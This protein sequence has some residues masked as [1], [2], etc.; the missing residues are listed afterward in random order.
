M[1]LRGHLTSLVETPVGDIV[2]DGM[3]GLWFHRLDNEQL[4]TFDE[5]RQVSGIAERMWYAPR[6]GG[7]EFFHQ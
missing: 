6:A 3:L 7:H 1:G 5:M 4:A 2:I